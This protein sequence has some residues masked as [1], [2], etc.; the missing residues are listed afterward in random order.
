MSAK[1]I[2]EALAYTKS[3]DEALALDKLPKNDY[4]ENSKTFK[5]GE[6]HGQLR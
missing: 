5:G 3:I 6:E 4:D 1:S 2:D